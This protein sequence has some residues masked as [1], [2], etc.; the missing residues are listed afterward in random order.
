MYR[1][2]EILGDK[3]QLVPLGERL[4][5]NTNTQLRFYG[6]I[7]GYEVYYSTHATYIKFSA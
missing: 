3:A 6:V 7:N 5:L 2:C 1:Q 4:P